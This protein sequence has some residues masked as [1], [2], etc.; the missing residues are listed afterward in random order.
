[1]EGNK[2]VIVTALS[3]PRTWKGSI[4]HPVRRR[5]ELAHGTGGSVTSIMAALAD[6]PM[7]GTRASIPLGMPIELEVIFEISE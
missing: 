3:F 7:A 6:N 1:M 2:T 4:H 5:A